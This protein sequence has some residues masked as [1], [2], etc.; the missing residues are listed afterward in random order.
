MC[1]NSMIHHI[2]IMQKTV[3]MEA[4]RYYYNNHLL[5]LKAQT[6]VMDI[7]LISKI[8]RQTESLIKLIDNPLSRGE[9]VEGKNF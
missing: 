9:R 6:A 5:I 3:I 2:S 1:E 8:I 7:H 4:V